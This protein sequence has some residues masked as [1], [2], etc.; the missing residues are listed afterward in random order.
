MSL[1]E[2]FKSDMYKAVDKLRRLLSK[3]VIDWDRFDRALNGLPDI[4]TT[5][6]EDTIL[7]E[8]Y[9]DCPDGI[10]LVEI[11]KRFLAKGYDVRANVGLNGSKCLH[12]LCWAT[13]DRYILDAAK[14]LLDAG[15]RTDLPLDRENN[16]ETDTGVKSSIS[17]RLGDW[18]MGEYAVVNIFEA[19]WAIVEAV[20]AGK[21]YHLIC[22]F[23]DCIGESFVRADFVPAREGA[24]VSRRDR[25]TFFDGQLV[26]WF[27]QKPLVVSKYIDFVVNPNVPGENRN[28]IASISGFFEP[29]LNA[30]LL[31][32][33]F[34][35]QC[36]AQL[37]FDNG[38]CLLFSSTDYRD[39][40]NRR[41]FF[42]IR[43]HAETVSILNKQIR[44]VM[45][46]TGR[47]YSDTCRNYSE[48]S[49]VLLCDDEALLLCVHP[50]GYSKSHALHI[51][52]CSQAFVSDY[53]RH[54]VLPDLTPAEIISYGGKTVGIR[55]NCGSRYFYIFV[56]E[57]REL[58]MKLGFEEITE[59]EE[60]LHGRESQKLNF[61]YDP[62]YEYELR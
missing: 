28:T 18:V 57:S 39:K 4:N 21:D 24:S 48:P 8:L 36:T 29:L 19:Y 37:L 35:D 62:P 5:C 47:V 51:L 55:M 52:E 11:T 42:E 58:Q 22:G 7:S 56:D 34:V 54:L 38:M 23:E 10:V 20:E 3:P 30:K 16:D 50:T 61:R 60:L 53:R 15:A 49:A 45:L 40:D 44:K 2:Y 1:E 13:F 33:Q 17:W 31:E 26:L 6:E 25:L 41:G 14:L 9:H 27:G 32:F 46:T 43:R 59:Y 12:N